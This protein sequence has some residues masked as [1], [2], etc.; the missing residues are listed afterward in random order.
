MKITITRFKNLARFEFEV[1]GLTVFVG[2]NNAGKSSILQGIQFAISVAQ[3]SEAVKARWSRTGKL[4]TSIYPHDFIYSPLRDVAALAPNGHFKATTNMQFV[5]DDGVEGS[6]TIVVNRGKNKNISIKISGAVV[7]KK[8]QDTVNP[9]GIIVPG[10]AGIPAYEEFET[11]F[12]VRR[13]AARGDSNRV[14]RN[15]LLALKN[16]PAAWAEFST[17]LE[18]MF[19]EVGLNVSFNPDKDEHVQCFV[20]KD[21][22]KLPIDSCGTGV[23]Q[24]IQILSYVS[25]FHPKIL[26]LDE[27]DSHLHPNNQKKLAGLLVAL[28]NSGVNV[29]V[30]T[31]SKY[32][33]A[34]LMDSAKVHWVRNGAIVPEKENYCL[35]ALMDIGALNEGE[36]IRSAGYVVL[37]EDEDK[38]LIQMLL[39]SSGFNLANGEVWAYKGC[40]KV[41]TAMGLIKYIHGHN[42]NCKIIVH[43][44]RDYFEDSEVAEYKAKFSGMANV[45]VFIPEKNDLESVFCTP[46]HI[47]KA[48]GISP[49]VA[50]QLYSDVFEERKTEILEKIIN[51]RHN[52]LIK[53]GKYNAGEIATT[54]TAR[55]SSDPGKYAHGKI[56]LAGLREKARTNYSK[57]LLVASDCTNVPELRALLTFPIEIDL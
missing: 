55:L 4:A 8:L 3:T 50:K 11:S 21:G 45:Y 43:R 49:E 19:P 40:S 33:L 16:N 17:R 32:L 38:T 1:A 26:I 34:A 37:T 56:M 52:C 6:S 29:V 39:Q 20:S 18:R 46:S 36:N 42:P 23:L 48:C 9:F 57:D 30:S 27:P 13:A 47:S 35:K 44:D 41:D 10:L 53:T 28:S 15:I 5:F 2:G 24:A 31:H 14:F 12:V 51:T 25:L 22:V 7:G 54:W